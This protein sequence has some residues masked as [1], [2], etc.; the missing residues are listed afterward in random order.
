VSNGSQHGQKSSAPISTAATAVAQLGIADAVAAIK[1]IEDKRGGR[2]LICLTYNNTS[3][4]PSGLAFP[5]IDA[6]GDTL[7][8]IGKVER[9]DFL[10]RTTGGTMEVPWRVVSLLREFTDE[11]GV[12]V[13]RIALSGG[14]HIAIAADELVMGPFAVIGSVDPTN[15]HPLLPKDASNQP[16]PTSVQD[17][18]HCIGFIREQLGESYPSQNLALIVSELF[19]YINPLALGALERTYSLARLI[20]EKV[21][22]TRKTALPDDQIQKIVDILSGQYFSHSYLISRRE[23]EH[24]LGLPVTAPDAELESIIKTFEESYLAEFLKVAQV[25]YPS[26]NTS[27]RIGALLQTATSGRL[28]AQF[29]GKDGKVV[30]DPWVK[31]R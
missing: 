2:R 30:Q 10:L 29:L 1:A 27:L 11:L 4:V 23:V 28:I 20:T 14:C 13:S 7:A 12:I 5:L 18:K 19:K 17:L 3:P 25:S 26:Q 21:L 31:F 22:K 9:L 16:I 6:L 8:E 15:S 24:D